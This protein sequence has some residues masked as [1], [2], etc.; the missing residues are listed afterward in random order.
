[1]S[2]SNR[3]LAASPGTDVL[4]TCSIDRTATPSRSAM[5]WSRTAANCS[6]QIGSYGT[7]STRTLGA[8]L[9]VLQRSTT[10][11]IGGDR[12]HR[13]PDLVADLADLEVEVVLA[14]V[15]QLHAASDLRQE[16]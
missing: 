1:M 5:S 2:T 9:S 13:R 14:G 11:D 7:T 10:L 4:P 16:L 6:V 12:G 15:D 3:G 8:G